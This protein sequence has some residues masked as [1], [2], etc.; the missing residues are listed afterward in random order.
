MTSDALAVLVGWLIVLSISGDL[1]SSPLESSIGIGALAMLTVL[2]AS[3]LDLYL[4]RVSTIRSVELAAL[5]RIAVIIAATS[6]LLARASGEPISIVVALAGA[7]TS[8]LLLVAC[9]S[10][11][12]AWI[13][14]RRR[15]GKFC[16][17]VLLVGRDEASVELFELVEDQPELGY[18]IVGFVGPPEDLGPGF[19]MPWAGDFSSL[20]TEVARREANG[21]I[22]A[23][24][25]LG[26]RHLQS[27]ISR[28]VQSGI[29]LQVS[30]GLSGIDRRRLRGSTV[31]YE[32]VLYLE[33]PSHGP[34]RLR[35][36]RVTDVVLAT[37]GM[38]VALPLLAVAAVAIKLHDR[39]PILFR[40]E[41][42]GRNGQR[43]DVLKLRT[44][45][46]DAEARLEELAGHNDRTGVL[47]K[48][49]NDPRV[50]R[51]GR[52]LR[53]TSID[54]LPQFINVLRG[55]MSLVGP[56]PALPSEVQQFDDELQERNAL[57]PG[58]TGLW[59]LEARDNPSF[60][61]YRRLDLFYLRNWS[62]TLDLVILVSTAYS[63]AIR[64]VTSAAHLVTRRHSET[65]LEVPASD[66]DLDVSGAAA[67]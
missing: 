54:E 18:R 49:E 23:A 66:G 29:H 60:R 39:G 9:R 59:Q 21:V 11:F 45:E 16:R 10:T 14:E 19:A 44:M 65:P 58:I 34:W 50:T 31:G 8:F 7:L 32:T 12:D 35:A 43:F 2:L 20:E 38:M 4:A 51:C 36:K 25:A 40:Q 5:I 27:A 62:L 57:R 52:L 15:R 47:F 48:L 46:I 53:A 63:V 1:A 56:R 37:F 17:R 13:K 22:I 41:R 24:S 26:E 6:L 61:L 64:A 67:T 42:V 28:L 3:H 33:R 30:T 55:E